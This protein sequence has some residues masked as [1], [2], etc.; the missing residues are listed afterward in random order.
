MTSS[1]FSLFAAVSGVTGL[2]VIPTLYSFLLDTN[3]ISLKKESESELG[4]IPIFNIYTEQPYTSDDA[5]MLGTHAETM[6]TDSGTATTAAT[7]RPNIASEIPEKI[8]DTK[9]GTNT[10]LRYSNHS[11]T[12][13]LPK[14]PILSYHGSKPTQNI[15]IPGTVPGTKTESN[16]I[17]QDTNYN[18]TLPKS[19]IMREHENEAMQ[20]TDVR[21][22]FPIHYY[23]GGPNYQ[24]NDFRIALRYAISQNRSIVAIEVNDHFTQPAEVRTGLHSLESTFD[25]DELRKI[26]SI[27]SIDEFKRACQSS[28]DGF[29]TE[30]TNYCSPEKYTDEYVRTTEIFEKNYGVKLPELTNISRTREEYRR[31]YEES[32]SAR[33]LGIFRPWDIDDW[34]LPDRAEIDRKID[35]HMKWAPYIRKMGEQVARTLCDGKPY[36]AVHWRNR[37][38][39][40]CRIVTKTSKQGLRYGSESKCLNNI[41]TLQTLEKLA[42]GASRDVHDVMKRHQLSCVYVAFPFYSGKIIEILKDADV[43]GIWS[44]A[45]ITTNE[46]PEIQAVKNDNYVTSLVEQEICKRSKIFIQRSESNWSE[47]VRYARDANSDVTLTMQR[48]PWYM[49]ATTVHSL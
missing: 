31:L 7:V 33:C 12:S 8:R 9:T 47:M 37:T 23:A 4:E 25:V 38:G 16:K 49:K 43:T 3:Y 44:F 36:L 34:R 45:N 21:Y 39:E 41:R 1:G 27:V 19:P 14:T 17:V 46:Y 11:P 13:T 5:W 35:M 40:P 18:P 28:F 15:D 10:L 29:I 48:L 22:L 24:Y 26:V 6:T 42:V 20:N 30:R 32:S 2:F